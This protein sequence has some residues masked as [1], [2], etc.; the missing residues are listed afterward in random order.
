MTQTVTPEMLA[1]PEIRAEIA[2]EKARRS[3]REFALYTDTTYEMNWHHRLLCDYLDDFVSGKK[4]RIIVSMPPRHGKSELASR[5]LPAYIFGKN[6]SAQI[7]T[8]S[9]SSDLAVRMNRDV[10]RIMDSDLYGDLFPTVSL[11]GKNARVKSDSSVARTTE[12]FGIVNHTGF[13]RSTGVGGGITGMGADYIILDDLVKNREEAMSPTTREKLWGWYTSTLLTRKEGRGCI[14][15]IMTRWHEDD[16]VGRLLDLAKKDPLADQWEVLN[17]PALFEEESACEGDVRSVGQALWPKKYSE[18]ELASMRVN[19]G[20]VDWSALYQGN[21]RP[22]NGTLFRREWTSKRYRVLPSGCQLIQTWDLPFKASESSA[23]CAGIIL[24]KKGSEIFF[25]DCINE[26][27]GFTESVAAIKNMTAKHPDARAKIVEDKANGPAIINFLQKDIS[28]MI[29]FNPK[30]SKED[31]ALSVAPY[32]EAGNVYFPENAP[33]VGDLV[34]DFVRFPNG[35]F[36]D[37]VDAAVQG[38]L[39]FMDKP[40]LSLGLSDGL[41]KG[42]YWGK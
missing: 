2:K 33:W 9:Y 18:K 12:S 11:G 7:I 39:Y 41:S 32:F 34:E 26:K 35:V 30:G 38:I 25:V 1:D 42:S 19:L 40:R 17:L 10:Q 36:K 4:D 8:A 20:S 13:Y 27:M 21:P 5:K 31:R 24:A 14:L 22:A 3:L 6:P 28:G 16:L 29:A 23:K 15:V 37:T